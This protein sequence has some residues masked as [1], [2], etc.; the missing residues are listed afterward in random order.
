MNHIINADDFI[1]KPEELAAVKEVTAKSSAKSGKPQKE[2]K[3][4][5]F[6]KPVMVAIIQS[7]YVPALAVA[8]AIHEAWFKSFQRNPITLTSARLAGFR[9]SRH[10]KLRALKILEQS[11][12]FLVKRASGRN[13][14]ITL[15]WLRI[16]D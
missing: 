13:P 14:V 1:I 11:G 15:K 16:K 9:I 4:F 2:I 7:G 3:F 8:A 5:Q 12:Y 6:P 10:Q